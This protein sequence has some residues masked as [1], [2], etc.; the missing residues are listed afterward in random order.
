MGTFHQFARCDPI[1]RCCV[2][3]GAAS[4][5]TSGE[6]PDRRAYRERMPIDVEC[7]AGYRGEQEP[8]ALRFGERRV[9]VR[10]IVDRWYSPSQRWFKVEAEDGD[11]YIVC[12]REPSGPWELA[13]YTSRRSPGTRLRDCESSPDRL[14]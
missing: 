6:L 13:A 9:A 10:S 14:S 1:G 7:C 8:V 11:T 4:T 2:T 5:L 12:R 3:A